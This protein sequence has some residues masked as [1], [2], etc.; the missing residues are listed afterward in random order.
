[1]APGGSA[2]LRPIEFEFRIPIFKEWRFPFGAG[3]A[4]DAPKNP[5]LTIGTNNSIA[6]ST[7]DL[8]SSV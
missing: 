1:M 2:V 7:V 4:I 3:L 5:M 8:T 6:G